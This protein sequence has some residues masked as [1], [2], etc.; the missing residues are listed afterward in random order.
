[1]PLHNLPIELLQSIFDLCP[2]AQPAL[3]RVSKRVNALCLPMMYRDVCIT[4]VVDLVK[5]CKTLSANTFAAL[6]M[7]RLIIHS[8]DFESLPLQAFED[9]VSA[10]LQAA[11]NLIALDID[12][13]VNLDNCL[14]EC[15]FPRLES[16][17]I[18]HMPSP[19][20]NPIIYDFLTRHRSLKNISI[21]RSIDAWPESYDDLPAKR[22]S[23]PKLATYSGSDAWLDVLL[24]NRRICEVGILSWDRYDPRNSIEVRH[25]CDLLSSS[26]GPIYAFGTFS[27]DWNYP[28]L[29][30]L[31]E[32]L[33]DV[34]EFSFIKYAQDA[35]ELDESE[36]E[37][38]Y[39]SFLSA[40]EMNILPRWPNLR[41]IHLRDVQPGADIDWESTE[42]MVHEVAQLCDWTRVCPNLK[43]CSFRSE[44]S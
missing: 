21:K 27:N 23:L 43:I 40:L 16:F 10:G 14:R 2:D 9:I 31:A 32:A 7:R 20:S 6:T 29:R 19:D 13:S 42:S 3:C 11:K 39:K 5:L 17:C 8:L 25:I 41:S 37:L 44:S 34:R 26:E 4:K 24:P 18:V 15:T 28:L 22:I 35:F 12:D 36:T 1:M 30:D 38:E 33:P